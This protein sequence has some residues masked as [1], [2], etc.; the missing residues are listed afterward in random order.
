MKA[1]NKFEIKVVHACSKDKLVMKFNNNLVGDIIYII[2][3]GIIHVVV[4]LI[5]N[6]NVIFKAIVLHTTDHMIS[7]SYLL[8]THIYL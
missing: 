8:Y 5:C 4:W 6:F 1:T 7:L 3:G 2:I